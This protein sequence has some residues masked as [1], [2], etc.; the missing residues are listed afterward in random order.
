MLNDI[1]SYVIILYV[2]LYVMLLAP[3]PGYDGSNLL[4]VLLHVIYVVIDS[5]ITRV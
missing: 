2:L 4:D 3:T 1:F 5:V